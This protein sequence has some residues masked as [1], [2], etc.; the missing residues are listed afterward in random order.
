[1]ATNHDAAAHPADQVPVADRLDPRPVTDR[2]HIYSGK[3]WDVVAETFQLSDDNPKEITREF[4]DHPGAV[5][6]LALDETNRVLMIRQYRHPV[7]SVLWEIPAGLLDVPGEDYQDA[8]A[9]ELGEE[10]DVRA[11]D[12]RVL[13]DVYTSAGSSSEAIRIY[14]AT[15]ITDVPEDKRHVRTDEES[16]IVTEWVPLAQAVQAALSGRLHSFSAVAG[17]LAAHAAIADGV[18]L[19]PADTPWPEHANQRGKH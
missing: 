14:L 15:G 3:I 6:I 10:A 1:M 19:R 4:I 11:Q 2:E 8:A 18:A 7:R 9:R 16:E 13:T 17:V 5:A 12:W